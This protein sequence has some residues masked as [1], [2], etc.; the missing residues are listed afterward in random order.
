MKI[1]HIRKKYGP[2]TCENFEASGSKPVLTAPGPARVVQGSDFTN[3]TI[4]LFLTAKFADAARFYRM[5][6]IL[7][8]ASLVISRAALC[9]LAMS[10]GRSVADLIDLMNRDIVRSPVIL[11]D[12]T[13]LKVL[14]NGEGLA[15]KSYMW[16]SVGYLDGKPIRRFAYHSGRDGA[17]ADTLLAGFSKYLQTDGYSGYDHLAGNSRIIHVACFAHIRRKFVGAWKVAGK[18]GIAKEAID[19]IAR[20]YRV[21]NEL[22]RSLDLKTIDVEGFLSARKER[23]GTIFGEMRAWLMDRA[24][25]VAPE[26]KLG[27]AIVY[28]Q[29][30]FDDAIRFIEHPCLRPDTN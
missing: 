8:R 28:A 17:F 19:L 10:V 22:R 3:R 2:C 5:A 9:K 21:E 7:D 29:H 13:T 23:L 6:K 4:A 15:G 30:E 1:V 24:L 16:V 12:E 25:I 27:K 18:K 26:C 11:M 14:R 20:I